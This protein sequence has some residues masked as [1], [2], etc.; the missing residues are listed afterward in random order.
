M[1]ACPARIAPMRPVNDTIIDCERTDEHTTHSGT[2]RDYA[3]PGSAT[4]IS[5]QDG[6]RRNFTGDLIDCFATPGCILPA[7]HRGQCAS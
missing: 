5:W 6:D 3:Y 4:T 7:G 1:S 2:L